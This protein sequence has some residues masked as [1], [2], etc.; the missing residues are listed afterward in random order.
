MIEKYFV[1]MGM[2]SVGTGGN[3]DESVSPCS[4]LIYEKVTNC[5][6]CL[7]LVRTKAVNWTV[8]T[9]LHLLK[10]NVKNCKFKT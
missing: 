2:N 7:N 10:I 3:G 1:G 8:K 5:T 9:V 6:Q 4:C